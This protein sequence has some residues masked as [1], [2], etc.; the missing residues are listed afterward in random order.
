MYE[1]L[2]LVAVTCSSSVFNAS[3]RRVTICYVFIKYVATFNDYEALSVTLLMLWFIDLLDLLVE[4][5]ET[6][7]VDSGESTEWR[8]LLF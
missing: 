5:V 3:K 1:D 6:I 2:K 4:T 7:K 8:Y